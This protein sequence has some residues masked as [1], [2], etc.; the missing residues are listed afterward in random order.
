MGVLFAV[1]WM[2]FPQ[3]QNESRKVNVTVTGIKNDRGYLKVAV[4]QNEESYEE[5]VP[6]KTRTI[7]KKTVVQG[8]ISFSIEVPSG[9]YGIVILDDENNND[10]MDFRFFIPTEGYGFSNYDGIRK[11]SFDDM[12]IDVSDPK[13]IIEVPLTYL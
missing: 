7:S 6:F 2:L 5:E 8:E 1:L 11:P 10:K 12:S 4:Y 9:K 13:K 3:F